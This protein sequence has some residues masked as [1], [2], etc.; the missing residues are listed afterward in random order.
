MN[1][2]L[3]MGMILDG[4]SAGAFANDI[5][6]SLDLGVETADML[7]VKL[8]VKRNKRKPFERLQFTHLC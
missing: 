4:D 2:V 7:F 8:N 5:Q 6:L 1:W 3:F